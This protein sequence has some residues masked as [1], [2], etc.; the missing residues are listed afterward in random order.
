M[1]QPLEQFYCDT[2]DQLIQAP[3]QGMVEWIE[4]MDEPAH[5]FRIVHHIEY[6]PKADSEIPRSE[7]PRPQGC[8]KHQNTVKNKDI[9]L[10]KFLGKDGLVKLIHFIDVGPYHV[11]KYDGVQFEDGREF[12]ELFRR[13]Q[14]PY[15]EEA[16]KYWDR[17]KQ[18]GFFE[19][20]NEMW[21]YQPEVLE[22]IID[23]YGP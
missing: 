3:E 1:L 20:A 23:V 17:A 21:I 10:D 16:R 5:S 8:Y 18:D 14:L 15:Y 9:G 4:S 7:K 2:C 12:A 6:S 19:G 22:E 11:P 13:L